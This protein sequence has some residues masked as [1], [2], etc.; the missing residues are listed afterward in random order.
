MRQTLT[1]IRL[2]AG[3]AS[4]EVSPTNGGRVAALTVGG[5]ELLVRGD[6]ATDPLAW[7]CYPMVPFAGRVRNGEFAFAGQHHRL[8]TNL[9]PHAIHGTGFTSP[10]EVLDAEFDHVELQCELTWALGGAAHQHILLTDAALVCVLTVMAGGEAM[11]TTIG[12]HPWFVKPTSDRLHFAAMYRRDGQGV[13]TGERTEPGPRP[14]DDCFL[15]PQGRLELRYAPSGRVAGLRVRIASDCDHW[16]VYDEPAHAICV[17]PQSGPPDAFNLG[18][19]TT[20]APGEFMQRTMTI[21]WETPAT[22]R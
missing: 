18:L 17:E 4:V 12:W 10:W 20:L 9:A 6:A 1:V 5:R 15:G 13:C 2:E 3:D 22:G 7:G 21:S 16:V 8:T 14:W 19:A 11:P